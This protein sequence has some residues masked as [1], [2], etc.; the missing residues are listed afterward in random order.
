MAAHD[1]VGEVQGV[2]QLLQV[3]GGGQFVLGLTLVQLLQG[4]QCSDALLYTHF[5]LR[6]T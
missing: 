4:V 1:G 3:K 2:T 6:G 5:D